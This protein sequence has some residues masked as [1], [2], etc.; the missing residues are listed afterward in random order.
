MSSADE[1]S[2]NETLRWPTSLDHAAIVRRLV[3]VRESARANGLLELAARFADVETMAAA[4]IGAR[5]VAAMTGLQEKPEY[6]SIA[7]QL[8]MVAMNLK[9]LK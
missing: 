4:Q 2:E 5:V 6:H 3:Q 9:N 1:K 7:T 8:E